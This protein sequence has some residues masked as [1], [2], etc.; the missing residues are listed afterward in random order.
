MLLVDGVPESQF[1]GD[2]IVEPMQ[3]RKPVASLG[4]CRQAEQLD[5]REMIEDP[6][7]RRRRGVM[8]LIDDDDVEVVRRECIEVDRVQTLDRREDVIEASRSCSADPLLTEGRIAQRVA[9]RREALVKDL[10]A[11][12]DEQQP[13]PDRRCRSVA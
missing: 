2:A 8:E 6:F 1:G 5:G 3:D 12:G 10:L 7:V 13:R 11:V 9:E 4:S